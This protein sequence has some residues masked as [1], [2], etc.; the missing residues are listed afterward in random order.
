MIANQSLLSDAQK[1]RYKGSY[2]GLC[3]VLKERHGFFGRIA[4]TYDMTFLLLVLT[5][6]LEPDE[7]SGMERCA[8]HPLRRHYYWQNDVTTYAADMNVALAYHNCRD[9]Y[10][11]DGS[12]VGFREAEALQASYDVIRTLWPR[13]CDAIERELDALQAI[14]REDLQDPDAAAACFGRL[15]GELFVTDDPMTERLR[16]FGEALGRM[17]YLLDAVIDLDEDLRSGAY[18]PLRTLSA[19]G[20][21]ESEWKTLL[22]AQLGVCCETFERLPL[23][24]DTD[25]MRNIL[26]SGIW[27]R[28]DA[29]MHK[30]S[31]REGRE[32]P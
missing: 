30:K 5:S 6:M 17:I 19:R 32:T 25:L 8:A 27:Q 13:Q 4:L 1:T 16:P 26:Y 22:T 12:A 3:R 9:D 28:F 15:L 11:D 2:C 14:E 18:N 23:L 7:T 21:G 24:G 29:A 31:K 20:W 10:Q